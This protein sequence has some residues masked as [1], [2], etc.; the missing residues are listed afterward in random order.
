MLG[1]F[2]SLTLPRLTWKPWKPPG[3]F[4]WFHL[5]DG[6][7]SFHGLKER[8]ELPDHRMPQVKTLGE[9]SFGAPD[10]FWME[11]AWVC[12]RLGAPRQAQEDQR[13]QPVLPG[14]PGSSGPCAFLLGLDAYV[15]V[16]EPPGAGRQSGHEVPGD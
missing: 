2:V 4:G 13:G 6:P 9:G 5:P 14:P 16:P 1:F 10:L 12:R 3:P 11:T 8:K 15:R 7:G